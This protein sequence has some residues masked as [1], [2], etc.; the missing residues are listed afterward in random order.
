MNTAQPIDTDRIDGTPR[1]V[2]ELLT[3][4]EYGWESREVMAVV[5]NVAAVLELGDQTLRLIAH[6]LVETVRKNATTD[7]DWKEAVRATLRAAVQRL[8]LGHKDPPDQYEAATAL[9][10]EPAELFAREA[11]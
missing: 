10:I 8:L 6:E 1:I 11:A 5:R 9:V 7:W 4:R 3:S 2:R